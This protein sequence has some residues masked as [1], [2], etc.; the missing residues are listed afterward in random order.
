MRNLRYEIAP[1]YLIRDGDTLKIEVLET[2]FYYRGTEVSLGSIDGIQL[3][4]RQDNQRDTLMVYR[5]LSAREKI[6]ADLGMS[7]N[8]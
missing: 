3:H 8:E 5:T 7:V 6:A 1:P 2:H 4:L